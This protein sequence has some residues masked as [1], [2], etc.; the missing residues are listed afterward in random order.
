MADVI[1]D[2]MKELEVMGTL[3]DGVLVSFSGGKESLVTLDLCSRTFKRVVCF[4]M[5][6][7]PNLRVCEEQLDYGRKRYGVEILQ[8]PHWSTVAALRNGVYS[9]NHISKDWLPKD[10]CLSDVYALARQDSGLKLV[11]NGIKKADSEFRR[12]NVAAFQRKDVF[13]PLKDFNKLHVTAYLGLHKIPLP[14]SS[15]KSAT[16]VDLS[17]PSLCWLH[18]SYPDDFEKLLQWYPYADAAISRRAFFGIK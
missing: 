17:V 10:Y 4:F 12:K 16:G 7:V 14:K 11:A 9:P 15:G 8:Y 6:L 13:C 5:Y 18:D 3:Y 1:N 2:T